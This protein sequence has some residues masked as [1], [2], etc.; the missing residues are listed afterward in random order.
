MRPDETE[1]ILLSTENLNVS[2]AGKQVCR[3]L[4]VQIKAGEC[5][6]VLGKNGIGKTTFLHTLA[7]LRAPDSG[8]I[9][10]LGEPTH[11]WSRKK[12]AR[13]VGVLLQE[14]NDPF[15]STVFET[16]LIGRHPHL[17]AWRPER[18]KDY[19]IAREALQRTGMLHLAAQDVTTLSGGERQR[20]ALAT[21][22]AQMPRLYLLD[23]PTNHLD[24][25]YQISLLKTLLHT[26]ADKQNAVVMTLHDVNLAVRFC[27]H[28]ILF[29]GDGDAC[30]GSVEAMLSTDVLHKLY[31]H[32]FTRLEHANQVIYLPN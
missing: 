32:E 23:E 28:L 6:G 9:E 31:G 11:R 3:D 7:N 13:H 21:L 10:L 5:W 19:A 1:I 17:S 24:L 25:H 30:F 22:L 26:A 27:D 18:D 4:T 14:I 29:F 20:L 16:A 15:P 2:I 8:G 12:F